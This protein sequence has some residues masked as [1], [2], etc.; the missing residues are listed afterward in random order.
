MR[1]GNPVLTRADVA[2]I[3]ELHDNEGITYEILAEHFGISSGSNLATLIR[4]AKQYGYPP[5]QGDD[6][7]KTTKSS[8]KKSR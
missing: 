2:L 1:G 5:K 4:S 6:K 8:S 3:I 7:C